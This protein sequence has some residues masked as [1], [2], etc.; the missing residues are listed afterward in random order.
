MT[1]QNRG[2]WTCNEGSIV[3]D[4]IPPG[5]CR[6]DQINHVDM[7]FNTSIFSLRGY[8]NSPKLATVRRTVGLS[9]DERKFRVN[10]VKEPIYEVLFLAGTDTG[11]IELIDVVDSPYNGEMNGIAGVQIDYGPQPPGRVRNGND[12]WTYISFEFRSALNP[13]P[14]RRQVVFPP[15]GHQMLQNPNVAYS[16]TIGAAE[17]QKTSYY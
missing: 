2:V 17:I 13:G 7:I 6:Q 9:V 14:T 16:V 3:Q 5:Y 12:D 10:P 1:L 11:S 8:S 4:G 15:G